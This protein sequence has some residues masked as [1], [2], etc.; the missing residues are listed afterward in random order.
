M[1][2][3]LSLQASVFRGSLV[4]ILGKDLHPVHQAMMWQCPI[5]K[6]EEDGHSCYLRANL[7]HQKEEEQEGNVKLS[8]WGE[9]GIE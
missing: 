9:L 1:V 4:Q 8:A 5:Y 2:L 3:W 7:P 6:I